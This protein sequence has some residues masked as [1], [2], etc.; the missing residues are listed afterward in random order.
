M[1]DKEK[2][3]AMFDIRCKETKDRPDLAEARERIREDMFNKS[4]SCYWS[5]LRNYNERFGA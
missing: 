5:L 4:L 1:T 3:Q 2:I